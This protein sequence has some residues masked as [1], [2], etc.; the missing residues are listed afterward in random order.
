MRPNFL[1]GVWKG[2]GDLE[3][4]NGN[5]KFTEISEW[6]LLQTEPYWLYNYQQFTKNATTGENM[7]A[8]NGFWKI[9]PKDEKGMYL[10]EASFSH[11]GSLNEFEKGKLGLDTESKMLSIKLSANKDH[12][13]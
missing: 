7:H 6:K 4:S 9:F 12:H 3:T 13:F 10:I 11:P 1:E 2:S 8:E 5:I